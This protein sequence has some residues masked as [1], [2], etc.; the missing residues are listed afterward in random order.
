MTDLR[1]V[2]S[3]PFE[4]LLS[5]STF[6]K[7][8]YYVFGGEVITIV[9]NDP[10]VIT[11]TQLAVVEKVS[12]GTRDGEETYIVYFYTGEG[13]QEIYIP[14]SQEVAALHTLSR[15]DIFQYTTNIAGDAKD[16]YPIYD[17]SERKLLQTVSPLDDQKHFV[18]GIITKV[19]NLF[20]NVS[21]KF[22]H[23]I[24]DEVTVQYKMLS[25]SLVTQYTE[26]KTTNYVQSLSSPISLRASSE[27]GNSAYLAVM[28]VEEDIGMATDVVQIVLPYSTDNKTVV[29]GLDFVLP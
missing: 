10:T 8:C 7:S 18:F 28:M 3:I 25:S 22:G 29:E 4:T 27:T 20:A 14:S 26:E 5:Q 13:K 17:A 21:K 2:K 9:V 11:H 19:G 23:D 6:A 16:I 1:K 15:G 12:I 24:E